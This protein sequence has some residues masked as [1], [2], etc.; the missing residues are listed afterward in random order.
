MIIC[1]TILE[2][3]HMTD[4]VLVFHSG[5]LFCP[6]TP[7]NAWQK[8]ISTKW[9]KRLELSSFSTSVSKIMIICNYMQVYQK[10]WLYGCN[11]CFSCWAISLPFYTHNSPKKENINKMKKMSGVIIILHKCIKNHDYKL[12]C[13][14]DM[15]HDRCNCCFSF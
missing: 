4:V 11:C 7:L 15:V 6:F 9:K 13:S 14:L 3:W 8:K 2:I 5:Q 12:Y 1:Y 10:T